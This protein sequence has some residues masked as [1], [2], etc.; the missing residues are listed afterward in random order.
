MWLHLVN[1]VVYE[2]SLAAICNIS[3]N[4]ETNEVSEITNEYLEAIVLA[5]RAHQTMKCV[6]ESTIILLKNFTFSRGNMAVME[7]NHYVVPL[8]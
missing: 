8:V 4:V 5:M 3:M 6:Q 1:L 7:V 2:A